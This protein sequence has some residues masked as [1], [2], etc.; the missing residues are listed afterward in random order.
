M[1]KHIRIKSEFT[2]GTELPEFSQWDVKNEPMLFNCDA[3]HARDL[4]GPIT[5]AF[6]GAFEREGRA[7]KDAVIDTR[8]HMLMKGWFPCIPGWH[9]DDVERTAPGGQPNYHDPK[10]RPHH[11]MA[12]INGAICPTEFAL[13]E[14]HMPLIEPGKVVY[15][16]WHPMVDTLVENGVLRLESA[17]SNQIIYFNDR[18]FHQGTRAVADGW[19][20][21][22]RVTWGSDRK[23]TNEVRRQV[24]VY[25]DNPMEGW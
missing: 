4:G 10:T 15:R 1:T 18:T 12:L 16:E 8:V 24:Q 19:R 6:L 23:P 13:G 20:W 25:M 14:A 9:H 11:A 17:P 7:L 22:G 5:K 3:A 2:W 21:F